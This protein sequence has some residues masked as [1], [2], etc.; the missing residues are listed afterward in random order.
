MMILLHVSL[1]PRSI[2]LAG[3]PPRRDRLDS[4]SRRALSGTRR[5]DPSCRVTSPDVRAKLVQSADENGDLGNERM[6]RSR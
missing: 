1:V 6:R 4:R 5:R 3:V 2:S